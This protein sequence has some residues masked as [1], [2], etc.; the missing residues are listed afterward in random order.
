MDLKTGMSKLY[1]A[2]DDL[3]TDHAEQSLPILMIILGGIGLIAL[4][5]GSFL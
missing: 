4:M 1:H 3:I 2:L 5:V